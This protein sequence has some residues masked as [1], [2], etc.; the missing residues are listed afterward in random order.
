[1][2]KNKTSDVAKFKSGKIIKLHVSCIIVMLANIDG[3]DQNIS[4]SERK[5]QTLQL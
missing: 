4:D 1:M 3:H 2:N 5:L